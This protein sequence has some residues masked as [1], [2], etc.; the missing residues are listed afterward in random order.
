MSCK[1]FHKGKYYVAFKRGFEDCKKDIT[2]TIDKVFETDSLKILLSDD[3]DPTFLCVLTLTRFDYEDLKKQQG[4]LIDFDNFPA[5]LVRLLQQCAS[6]N[7]FLIM[8]QSNPLQYYLEIVEHNEFKRLVHLSLKTGPA[9][10]DDIKQHMAETILNLKKSLASLKTTTSSTEALLNDKCINLE[11]KVCDLTLAISKMEEDKLRK[12][13]EMQEALRMERERLTQERLQWQKN[14]EMNTKAQLAT[15]QDTISR[16][17]KYIEEL[18]TMCKQLRDS[19]GQL[20]NQISEKSQRLI[21]LEAEVQKSHI[22]VA[23]LKAKYATLDREIMEKDKLYSQANKKCAQLEMNV[24]ESS[25]TIKDLNNSLQLAKKE[26]ASL[27]ERL[28]FSE[29]LVAKS[30]DAA[31]STSEQLLKANQIISKQNTELIE[32]K[33]KL[34]CRTAIALEQ[35]KVIERNTKEIEDLKSEVAATKQNMDKLTTELENLKEK[36]EI[37]DKA[38]KDRDETIKNNNMVIQWL[39]KKLETNSAPTDALRSKSSTDNPTTSSSTPYFLPCRS[40]MVNSSDDSINFYATS[41]LSNIEDS[42]Q[43]QSQE[44]K[45]KMGLD[46]KYLQPAIDD[47]KIKSKDATKSKTSETQSQNGKENKNIDLPKVDY[48]EKKSARGSTYRATPVSAYFP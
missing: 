34:L 40:N 35:E 11:R 23:T 15:S 18:N 16:K 2:V 48:R 28:A 3:D 46:P 37:N 25:E 43:P 17:D 21:L 5:Q 45:T 27:E 4:L 41:K 22:E 36:Y 20:E 10:D 6:N 32:V 29:S 31:H 47:N 38:L 44:K 33:E 42:P 12:E 24:K 39:H 7:M 26:K 1:T 13:A 14:F 8:Q 9:T 30:N 19:I